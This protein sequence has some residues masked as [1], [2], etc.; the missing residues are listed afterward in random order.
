[1]P[2]PNFDPDG[3]TQLGDPTPGQ[4]S[5]TAGS[6]VTGVPLALVHSRVGAG[7]VMVGFWRSCTVT[8]AMHDAVRLF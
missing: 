5:E 8:L 7:H 4:L 3:G 6:S 2:S 1:M